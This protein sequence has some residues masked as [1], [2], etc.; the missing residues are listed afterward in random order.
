MRRMGSVA[1]NRRTNAP[2]E[3]VPRV[4]A[5]WCV[6]ATQGKKNAATFKRFVKRRSAGV[7]GTVVRIAVNETKEPGH[8]RGR[9]L[10]DFVA[11]NPTLPSENAGGVPNAVLS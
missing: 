4:L 11:R 6:S 9:A 7:V 5:T 3:N 8:K 1:F 2:S 10:P